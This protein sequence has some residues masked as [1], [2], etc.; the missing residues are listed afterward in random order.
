VQHHLLRADRAGVG[1]YTRERADGVVAHGED[2]DGQLGDPGRRLVAGADA[3]GERP[4][5]GLL[6]AAVEPHR[7]AGPGQGEPEPHPRPAGPA[8][9]RACSRRSTS[10]TISGVTLNAGLFTR[11]EPLTSSA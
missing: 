7:V 1:E 9:L 3:Q 5:H 10:S 11:P 6:G 4:W 8:T 2:D